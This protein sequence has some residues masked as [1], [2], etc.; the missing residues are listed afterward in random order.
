MEITYP[1]NILKTAC[2]AIEDEKA[3]LMWD[4]V[5]TEG[6]YVLEVQR[7]LQVG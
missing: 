2:E 6:A 1:H 7:M 5:I 3:E 4:T